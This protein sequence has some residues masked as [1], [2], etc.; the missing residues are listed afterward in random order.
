MTYQP[1]ILDFIMAFE[2]QGGDMPP[3]ELAAGFQKLI[4]TGL[5]W[6]LQG[7]YGRMA[8]D[9]IEQG[10]CKPHGCVVH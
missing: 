9:L 5:V 3:E 4:D 8:S 10:L 1:E 7:F 6:Q 2:D